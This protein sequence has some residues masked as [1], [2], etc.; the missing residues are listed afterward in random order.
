M[1][2]H[3]PDA[4]KMA[5]PRTE[6]VFDLRCLQERVQQLESELT[7]ANAEI[8]RLKAGG[9]ARDQRTTQFCAEAVEL[10]RKLEE[11]NK[12]IAELEQWIR[13]LELKEE[14]PRKERIRSGYI[15]WLYPG[16]CAFHG[17]QK[18]KGLR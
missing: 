13:G 7:A 15:D 9:C 17:P 8:A 5:T 3:I 2:N 1:S 12:R 14:N 10:A 18:P 4:N 11:A 6:T 16:E